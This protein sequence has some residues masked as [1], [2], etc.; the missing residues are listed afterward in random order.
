LTQ[1]RDDRIF[2]IDQ[3]VSDDGR[4]LM[5]AHCKIA[6]GGGALSPRLYFHD[7]TDGPTGMIHVGFVGPHKYVRNASTN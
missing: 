1:Y 7:D 5:Q 2:E 3:R 4:I 6:E